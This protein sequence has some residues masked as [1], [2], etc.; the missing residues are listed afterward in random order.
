MKISFKGR[1]IDTYASQDAKYPNLSVTLTD[2]DQ[3]SGQVKLRV[4][5]QL[6]KVIRLDGLYQIDGAVEGRVYGVNFGMTLTGDSKIVE[7]K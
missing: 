3:G 6:A 7:V 2:V 5:P 4:P 1:V